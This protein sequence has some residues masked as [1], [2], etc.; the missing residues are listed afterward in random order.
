MSDGTTV[1]LRPIRPEDEPLLVKFHGDLSERSV[2]LRYFQPFQLEQRTAHER[3]TRICF[4]DYD[5]EIA[6]VAEGKD[7][8]GGPAILA[9]GR[10]SKVPGLHEGRISTL[11][12]DNY[13][14]RG[15][16]TELVRQ[17]IQV[18]REEKLER[19]SAVI[20]KDNIDMQNICGHLRFSISDPGPD[21]MVKAQLEL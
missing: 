4:N 5:R 9:V 11:V 20:V 13:Q 14:G 16:G 18:A 3:L 8:A 10:L 1:T 15:M 6:L 19:I 7:E 12:S 2:Y 21:G 17:L